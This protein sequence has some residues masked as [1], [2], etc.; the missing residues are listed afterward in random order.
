MGLYTGTAY[1]DEYGKTAASYAAKPSSP[2]SPP[3]ADTSAFAT[4]PVGTAG[5]PPV[6]PPP[7]APAGSVQTA[8]GYTPDWSGLIQSDPAYLSAQANARQ[9]QADAAAQRK[10]AL[11]SAITQYGG[12]PSGF[13][14]QYGDVD[15]ATLDAAGQNQFSTLAQLAR[16]YSQNED[17]FKRG[18]AARGALQSGDLNYGEDQLQNAYGQQRYDAANAL[19][20]TINQALGAYSGVLNSNAQNLTGAIQ[21]AES[22]VDAN[23]SYRPTPASTANYDATNSA[24]YGQPIYADDGGNL[25][26]QNGNPFT[27]PAPTP[28]DTGA[29]SG[30]DIYVNP[31]TGQTQ[32]QRPAYGL[33]MT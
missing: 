13:S 2:S 4:G 18:L 26:D 17:Q 32:T 19:S 6:V 25:F 12:L 21:G 5:A 28:F 22:N 31:A 11:R 1:L 16:N 9:A 7:A 10:A 14:D 27:P 15:Q 20:S 3:G 33:W 29:Q 24:T 8:P 23:P 30:G